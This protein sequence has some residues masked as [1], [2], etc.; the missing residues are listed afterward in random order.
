MAKSPPSKVAADGLFNLPGSKNSNAR[1]PPVKNEKKDVRK[2]GY[3]D[4]ES[5]VSQP[6]GATRKKKVWQSKQNQPQ[7]DDP[8]FDLAML[9]EGVV[10]KELLAQ[11][12]KA[13]DQAKGKSPPSKNNQAPLSHSILPRRSKTNLPI[14]SFQANLK[15]PL[16]RLK[17]RTRWQSPPR[18]SRKQRTRTRML[19]RTPS[20]VQ[21][22][23]RR[24]PPRKKGRPNH[25]RP[26]KKRQKIRRR[27]QP[28]PNIFLQLF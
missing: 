8:N 11:Q 23:P 13:L 14:T 12:Q 15:R 3:D 21:R 19:M 6:F 1:S 9:D 17:S 16:T 5:M 27:S 25:P 22:G 24:P 20:Q 10:P 4:F 28:P 26:P 7:L 18:R 2:G